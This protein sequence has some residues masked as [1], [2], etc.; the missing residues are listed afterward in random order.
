M[1]KEKVTWITKKIEKRLKR[2]IKL[3]PRLPI[4][5]DDCYS[6][7]PCMEE[8]C[9]WFIEEE[10]CCS[11]LVLEKKNIRLIY[12]IDLLTWLNGLKLRFSLTENKY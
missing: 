10:K 9:A 12:M 4:M 1:K 11:Q 7:I 5:F 2:G 3:C 8:D 6:F